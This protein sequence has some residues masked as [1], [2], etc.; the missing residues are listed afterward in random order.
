MSVE[1]INNSNI[2]KSNCQTLVNTVNCVGVMGAG[3]ALEFKYRYPEMFERYVK[4]CNEHHIQIGKLWIYNV[5]N[6]NN[7]VLNFPT[8]NHFKYPSKYE[9]I[10]KGLERFLETYKEKGVESI[11][12]PMLGARNGGLD[13]EKIEKIMCS[14]LDK[15]EIPVEIYEYC[16]EASDDLIDNFKNLLLSYDTSDLK[17]LMHFSSNTIL[18]LKNVLF[19]GRVNS[20]IQLLNIK[21]FSSDVVGKCFNFAMTYKSKSM[22]QD[23]FSTETMNSKELINNLK[24]SD[25]NVNKYSQKQKK[26]KVLSVNEKSQITGLSE[27]TINKIE[28][29]D[30]DVTI[31]EF[32]SYCEKLKLNPKTFFN[33]N[34]LSK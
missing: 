3:I 4:L 30:R 2:F 13:P 6:K 15:C 21:G 7:K 16:P 22:L 29:F 27:N 8:K 5:P 11:A 18:N 28:V 33:K 26:K 31:K 19:D 10:E 14:Y 20:L 23:M 9:Y 25:I 32:L 1:K 34:F 17:R 24:V 12:F